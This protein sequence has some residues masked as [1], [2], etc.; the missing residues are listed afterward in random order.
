MLKNLN[1]DTTTENKD[2]KKPLRPTETA[3][4]RPTPVPRTPSI[5]ALNTLNAKPIPPPRPP[6]Q[7]TSQVEPFQER[8]TGLVAKQVKAVKIPDMYEPSDP[9]DRYQS[10][11]V[12]KPFLRSTDPSSKMFDS[13]I[14]AENVKTPIKP[15][16]TTAVRPQIKPTEIYHSPTEAQV[17]P[18]P[19]QNNP[20][21]TTR[22]NLA[23]DKGGHDHQYRS[24]L[25]GSNRLAK[26]TSS[27]YDS[28][29]E[30]NF[31]EHGNI[32]GKD[33]ADIARFRA[34]PGREDGLNQEEN[35]I[36]G[37]ALNKRIV[38]QTDNENNKKKNKKKKNNDKDNN[39]N[40]SNSNNNNNSNNKKIKEQPKRIQYQGK[41]ATFIRKDEEGKRP[42]GFITCPELQDKKDLEETTAGINDN[43][44]S[45]DTFF[46]F[47]DV[48]SNLLDLQR[49][50]EVEF[51]LFVSHNKAARNNNKP[52]AANVTVVK[53]SKRDHGTIFDYLEQVEKLLQPAAFVDAQEVNKVDFYRDGIFDDY[54]DIRR[55]RRRSHDLFTALSD[56]EKRGNDVGKYD[57]SQTMKLLSSPVVW[58]CLAEQISQHQNGDALLEKFLDTIM[59]LHDKIRTLDERFRQVLLH[60]TSEHK[61][62]NP[63][64]GRFRNY[65]D[66]LRE[67]KSSQMLIISGFHKKI[68]LIHNFLLLVAKM[69]PQ[70]QAAILAFIKPLMENPNAETAVFLYKILKLTAQHG[71][72][73]IDDL[74]WKDL[75]LILKREEIFNND[76]TNAVNLKPVKK[77]GKYNSVEDYV[78]VYFRLLREDC[79][80]M[81]KKS[82]QDL[83]SGN[84]GMCA[85]LFYFSKTLIPLSN[86]D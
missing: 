19:E 46:S 40:N 4:P 69:V 64:R 2:S 8:R 1:D 72:F 55:G 49:G 71:D 41:V 61:F 63:V 13:Q 82:I 24:N 20:A 59:L 14:N 53:L 15:F 16:P 28:F 77:Q 48:Q 39:K 18:Q 67:A 30:K 70:K 9:L 47:Q 32:K 38:V 12:Q 36:N 78:D 3:R 73:S 27:L 31:I 65:V 10:N 35:Q 62:F 22:R 42:F 85:H 66:Q 83:L 50:D 21:Y 33:D 80:Y 74:D 86:S 60:I 25:M 37:N 51:R 79:F 76:L 26:S 11:G 23:T 52:K 43:K 58:Q 45:D 56:D 57:P 17:L 29:M 7:T 34:P 84:L 75:P 81:L 44:K 6:R 5:T 68:K 54:D